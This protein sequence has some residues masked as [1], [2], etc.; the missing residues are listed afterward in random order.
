M[1]RITVQMAI[2]R[3]L[4]S[5]GKLL[6]W[7]S[8]CSID[9][10]AAE[11]A[12]L[13]GEV[14]PTKKSERYEFLR[15]YAIAHGLINGLSVKREVPREATDE[16]LKSSQW[17]ALRMHA[18]KKY[19][20]RCACCGASPATGAVMNVDH[21]KPRKYY[22]ELALDIDNLQVLC[23]QCNQGKGNW[24]MTDWRK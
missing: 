3:Y 22:P 23:G 16:F 2:T 4:Q 15:R 8:P 20:T 21:I 9:V 17:R 24:D 5:R 6:G 1:K 14:R 7:T 19:G 11:L 12:A 18:F 13:I 10:L